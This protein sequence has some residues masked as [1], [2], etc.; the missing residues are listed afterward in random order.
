M[1]PNVFE[2]RLDKYDFKLANKDALANVKICS[3]MLSEGKGT[4]VTP[5]HALGVTLRRGRTTPSL[6]SP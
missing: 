4:G 2:I 1:S 6:P 5:S 3:E